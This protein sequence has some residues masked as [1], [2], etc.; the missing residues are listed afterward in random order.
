[1]AR[2]LLSTRQDTRHGVRTKCLV[3]EVARGP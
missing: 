2:N 1:M 3:G